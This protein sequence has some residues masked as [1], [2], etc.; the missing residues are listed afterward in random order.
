MKTKGWDRLNWSLT[1]LIVRRR[2]CSPTTMRNILYS[3][4]TSLILF[5]PLFP[6]L[7]MSGLD[8]EMPDR[9]NGAISLLPL[10]TK[11]KDGRSKEENHKLLNG[12]STDSADWV[13]WIRIFIFLSCKL[14]FFFVISMLLIFFVRLGNPQRVRTQVNGKIVE[15]GK[16]VHNDTL[17]NGA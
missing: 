2:K 4:V 6:K 5:S 11:D 1:V 10:S 9:S 17:I 16:A 8:A 14:I 3:E 7:R 15:D 12:N 13:N